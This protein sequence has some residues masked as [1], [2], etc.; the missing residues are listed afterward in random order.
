ME[1]KIEIQSVSLVKKD[2]SYAEMKFQKEIHDF[3][4]SQKGNLL[5]YEFTFTNTGDEELIIEK[6]ESDCGCFSYEISAMNLKPGET[7]TIK[8]ILDTATQSGLTVRKLII[9]SN[10]KNKTKQISVTTEVK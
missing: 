10:I 8:V 9:Y 6:I 7:A 1:R 2:S 5:T 4:A 3:G